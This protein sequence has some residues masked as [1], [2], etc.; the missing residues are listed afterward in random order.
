MRG[1]FED[2]KAR[3]AGALRDALARAV[4]AGELG[5]GELPIPQ[6]EVPQFKA[7]GD[8]ATNLA[9]VLARPARKAPREVAEIIIRHLDTRDTWIEGVEV[10]GP[11]FMNFRLR[12]GWLYPVLA[13]IQELGEKYGHT[14]FGGGRRIQVEFVS[15]NPTGP[16]VVV[17]ARAGAVGD[18]LASLLEAAGYD[19]QRE[20]YI[21]DAGNQI[22][23]LGR[24]MDIRYRQLCGEDLEV[25]D[26]C[27]PGEYLIDLARAVYE[28]EGRALLDRPED[29]RRRYLA[30]YAVS[31]NV[32]SQKEELRAYGVVYDNW[33][34]EKALRQAGGPERVIAMFK[35]KGYTYEQDGALWFR[36][37]AFGDDKD[38]VLVKSDERGS[39]TYVVPDIAYHLNKLERGFDKLINLL[40]PDHHGYVGRMRAAIQALGYPPDVLEV[41]IVQLVRLMRGGEPVRMSKRAG[42]IFPMA[43]LLD[44]VGKDAA[45]FFFLLR[46][47]DSHLD[48][49]L[50]LAKLQS[51]DNPVFYVQY[52][53]ARISS[54]LRQGAEQGLSVPRADAVDLSVLD[55]PSELELLRKL[56]GFPEEIIA[57]AEAREPHRMTRYAIDLATLFHAFYTQCRVLGNEPALTGA[58]LVLVDGTR[59]VLRNALALLGVTAPERM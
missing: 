57:A 27:Y 50:D 13:D 46:S 40:G 34:S 14:D 22:E 25:P 39:Y 9:M 52:A 6:L 24:S 3:V 53:H 2:L 45:R 19:V 48:F 1:R 30:E 4:A 12:P 59:T 31:E 49:D 58:R 41:V 43:D 28:R 7:H 15:A 10:A 51:N 20:F 21:N 11:G 18:T 47:P 26:D 35:E 37:T 38:R 54:I 56:A 16:L 5:V 36:S 17:S 44:E 42:N 32:R 23:V 33:F 29:D 8:L 55:H